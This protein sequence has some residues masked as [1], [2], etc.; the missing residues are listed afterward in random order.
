MSFKAKG[1]VVLFEFIKGIGEKAQCII[2]GE[3][4]GAGPFWVLLTV[5]PIFRGAQASDGLLSS[6]HSILPTDHPTWA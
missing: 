3:N 5:K 1:R 6:L 4:Q 2:T